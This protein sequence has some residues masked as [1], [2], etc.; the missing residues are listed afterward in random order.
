MGKY[1]SN[2]NLIL[3]NQNKN[4]FSFYIVK[5]FLEYLA[6]N[7]LP[8][9]NILLS[10]ENDLSEIKKELEQ[11]TNLSLTFCSK[12]WQKDSIINKEYEYISIAPKNIGKG[13]ALNILK[14]YLNVNSNDILSIGDNYNDIDLLKNSGVSVAIAN[15]YEPVKKVAT[16]ITQNSANNGGF[17]EAVYHFMN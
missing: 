8:I 12:R 1:D 13:Y 7:N 14:D 11:K 5:N 17:A 4:G 3:T 9:F 16:Y 6:N 10:S 15:A 2:F